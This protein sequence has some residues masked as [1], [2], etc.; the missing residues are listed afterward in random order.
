MVGLEPRP[1]AWVRL[2]LH[3]STTLGHHPTQELPPPL[4]KATARQARLGS[5][6]LAEA[7]GSGLL[8]RSSPAL[9]NLVRTAVVEEKHMQSQPPPPIPHQMLLAGAMEQRRLRCW[10]R[11]AR[12]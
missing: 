10:R 11:S 5:T 12:R 1:V 2:L 3:P 6:T 4:R 9:W 8:T 7:L